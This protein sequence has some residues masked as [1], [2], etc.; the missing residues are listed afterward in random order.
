MFNMDWNTA[1][2]HSKVVEDWLRHMQGWA[3][4]NDGVGMLV[5]HKPRKPIGHS[6]VLIDAGKWLDLTE[7]MGLL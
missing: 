2:W 1:W 4:A 5:L 3:D 6:V 7:A